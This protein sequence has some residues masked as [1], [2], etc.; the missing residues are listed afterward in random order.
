MMGTHPDGRCIG[1]QHPSRAFRGVLGL[2]AGVLLV[3]PSW[4]HDAA[5]GLRTDRLRIQR[6]TIPG[7]GPSHEID[8]TARDRRA[9]EGQA[10]VRAGY[11]Q[12]RESPLLFAADLSSRTLKAGWHVAPRIVASGAR[13]VMGAA[14]AGLVNEAITARTIGSHHS[15]DPPSTTIGGFSRRR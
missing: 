12:P 7:R 6:A 3:S 2:T 14:A 10:I 13:N 11:R 9:T 4:I 15:R 1:L 5:F 8:I